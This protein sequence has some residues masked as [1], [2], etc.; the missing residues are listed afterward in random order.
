M[1]S[2][3]AEQSR[4]TVPPLTRPTRPPTYCFPATVPE[5]ETQLIVALLVQPKSPRQLFADGLFVQTRLRMAWPLPW[6]VPVNGAESLP[7]GVQSAPPRSMSAP[8]A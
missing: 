1:T 8:S 2:T 3:A 5:M 7:M 4:M 6:S